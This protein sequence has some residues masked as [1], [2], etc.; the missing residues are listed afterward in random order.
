MQSFDIVTEIKA[1]KSTGVN[2]VL[3]NLS[4]DILELQRKKHLVGVFHA[5]TQ[6]QLLMD[7]EFLSKVGASFIEVKNYEDTYIRVNVMKCTLLDSNKEKLTSAEVHKLQSYLDEKFGFFFLEPH[8]SN[9]TDFDSGKTKIFAIDK[10][11]VANLTTLVVME[12]MIPMLNYSMLV[13]TTP[14]KPEVKSK[15]MKI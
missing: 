9:D 3:D 8:V 11:L 7:A 1:I 12:E 14:D 13:S 4:A 2:S 5:L 10:D 6:L 15:G